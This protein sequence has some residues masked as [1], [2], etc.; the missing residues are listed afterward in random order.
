MDVDVDV[1]PRRVPLDYPHWCQY[2]DDRLNVSS[3]VGVS[4]V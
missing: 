2:D 4:T 3:F 1:D